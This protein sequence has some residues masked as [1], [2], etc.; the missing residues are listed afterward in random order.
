MTS[1]IDTH[2]GQILRQPFSTFESNNPQ[3]P[4]VIDRH[5][6]QRSEQNASE[7]RKLHGTTIPVLYAIRQHADDDDA[8]SFNNYEEVMQA[9][10]SA[11]NGFSDADPRANTPPMKQLTFNLLGY[12]WEAPIFWKNEE[13]R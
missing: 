8:F 13:L 12:N 4:C 3:L 7:P 2:N 6:A 10:P 1:V 11:L 9:F 5:A